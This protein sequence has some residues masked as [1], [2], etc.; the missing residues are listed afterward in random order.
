MTSETKERFVQA[1]CREWEYICCDMLGAAPNREMK[2][3]EVQEVLADYVKEKAGEILPQKNGQSAWPKQSQLISAYSPLH[4][5]QIYGRPTMPTKINRTAKK[6]A[7][8][9]AKKATGLRKPQIRVLECLA[10]ANRSFNRSDI[11]AE[12][13]VDQAML[14]EYVGSLDEERRAKNDKKFPS[15]LTL[16]LVAVS[17]PENGARGA[18]YKITAAGRKALEGGA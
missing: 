2:A 12:A 15:L 5:F 16:K 13:K 4:S 7:K 17:S 8:R 3:S 6:P 14:V 11:S 1:C 10:K 9:V 18:Y